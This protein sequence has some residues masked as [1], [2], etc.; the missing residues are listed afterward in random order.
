[1]SFVTL[2]LFNPQECKS[3][4]VELLGA[5]PSSVTIQPL[6]NFPLPPPSKEQT[7]HPSDTP[8]SSPSSGAPPANN[9]RVGLVPIAVGLAAILV[10]AVLIWTMQT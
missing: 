10:A 8:S 3:R 7:P 4:V 5:D 6:E 1:M 9:Q 2:L